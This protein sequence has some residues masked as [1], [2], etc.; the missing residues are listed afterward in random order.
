MVPLSALL[1]PPLNRQHLI[2][3]TATA[4]A[5]TAPTAVNDRTACDTDAAIITGAGTPLGVM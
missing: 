5:D 2:T 1:A 3:Q 4:A